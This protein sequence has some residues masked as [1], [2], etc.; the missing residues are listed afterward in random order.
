M[1]P[2]T[3][4][5]Y[6]QQGQAS[7]YPKVT[8]KNTLID[9]RTWE[10]F[11]SARLDDLYKVLMKYVSESVKTI[12]IK[13][14]MKQNKT[15]VLCM[16]VC[17]LWCMYVFLCFNVFSIVLLSHFPFLFDVWVISKWYILDYSVVQF[18]LYILRIIFYIKP[19]W[20]CRVLKWYV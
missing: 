16:C 10:A 9:P 14:R 13:Q 4:A 3:S 1:C 19:L 8:V 5:V 20:P 11:V 15:L 18:M 2:V 12:G 17:A 7:S 6:S